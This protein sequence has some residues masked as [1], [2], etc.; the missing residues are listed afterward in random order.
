MNDQTT[1]QPPF[2]IYG[3]IPKPRPK[4][5]PP[6]PWKRPSDEVLAS[7]AERL[8]QWS[9]ARPVIQNGQHTGEW[10]VSLVN[11]RKVFARK[12]IVKPNKE[13][14]YEWCMNV[15]HLQRQNV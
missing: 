2:V 7:N 3:K 13:S 6:T 10:Q 1:D 14:A 12:W 9:A 5:P 15:E 4:E 11:P 8:W